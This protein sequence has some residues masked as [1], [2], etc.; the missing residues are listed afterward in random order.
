MLLVT[1]FDIIFFF[2]KIYVE[3]KSLEKTE[4]IA[5]SM[6]GFQRVT[7]LISGRIPYEVYEAIRK[8]QLNYSFSL[9]LLPYVICSFFIM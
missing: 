7:S 2:S 3:Y 1:Y 4:N 8:R 6:D 5:V 9:Q